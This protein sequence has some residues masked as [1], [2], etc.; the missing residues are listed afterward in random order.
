[1][2][3]GKN[4]FCRRKWSFMFQSFG[5]Y[6]SCDLKNLGTRT[7]SVVKYTQNNAVIF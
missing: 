6:I 4:D 3:N 1:M 2:R 5:S 7:K